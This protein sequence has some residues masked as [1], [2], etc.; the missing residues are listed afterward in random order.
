[1]VAVFLQVVLVQ[2]SFNY[3]VKVKNGTTKFWSLLAG[4][5]YSEVVVSSGLTVHVSLVVCGS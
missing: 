2:R 1:M 3:V 5:R 4:G